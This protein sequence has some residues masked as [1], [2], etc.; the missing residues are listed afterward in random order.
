MNAPRLLLRGSPPQQHP[1]LSHPLPDNGR[2]RLP[3]M[4]EGPAVP[5]ALLTADT[6]LS[7]SPSFP[8]ID[9]YILTPTHIHPNS[10]MERCIRSAHSPFPSLFPH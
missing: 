9:I 8:Q 2:K 5:R 7:A 3:G 4:R 10:P 6:F 1:A